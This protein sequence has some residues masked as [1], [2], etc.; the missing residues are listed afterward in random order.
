M[1]LSPAASP[2]NP[3]EPVSHPSARSLPPIFLH[4]RMPEKRAAPPRPPPAPPNGAAAALDRSEPRSGRHAVTPPGAS[5]CP[6]ATVT[7][8]AVAP[9]Q[10][11]RSPPSLE[12]A[13]IG[14]RMGPDRASTT[15]AAHPTHAATQHHGS[16]ASP[17]SSP[18]FS[19]E[20][21]SVV[22]GPASATSALLAGKPP[23]HAPAA[24]RLRRDGRRHR[25]RRRRHLPGEVNLVGVLASGC[26]NV[27]GRFCYVKN[28][29]ILHMYICCNL[30]E[31]AIF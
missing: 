2:A 15:Q 4:P 9:S 24:L 27:C 29:T 5:A 23:R 7:R 30:L 31:Y 22:H 26:I 8:A 1:R 13:Q 17:F 12:R 11:N 3:K 18:R 21:R 10:D 19:A 6:R 16:A 20:L 25:R 14:P 28:D